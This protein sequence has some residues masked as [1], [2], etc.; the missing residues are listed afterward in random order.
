MYKF[1]RKKSALFAVFQ[2]YFYVNVRKGF[3]EKN[4]RY[5]LYFNAIL[6]PMYENDHNALMMCSTCIIHEN[7]LYFMLCSYLTVAFC[8][9]PSFSYPNAQSV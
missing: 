2:C 1:F 6:M 7:K 8:P 9:S 3:F 5:F 4:Q